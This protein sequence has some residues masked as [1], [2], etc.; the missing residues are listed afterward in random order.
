MKIFENVINRKGFKQ[1]DLKF[2]K[3]FVKNQI[4]QYFLTLYYEYD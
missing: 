4:F 2:M 1:E 3:D